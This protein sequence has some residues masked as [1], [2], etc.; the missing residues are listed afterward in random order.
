MQRPSPSPPIP[1]ASAQRMRLLALVVA[2]WLLGACDTSEPRPVERTEP[3]RAP[4][5]VSAPSSDPDK[6][7]KYTLAPKQE[8]TFSLKTP[9]TTITG[10]F[11]IVRGTL[12]I[13]PVNLKNS[14]AHLRIDLGAVRITSGS[15]DENRSYSVS[16]QNWLNLG[17][18]IP[19]ASRDARRW[20]TVLLEEVLESDASSAHDAR[21]DRKRLDESRQASTSTSGTEALLDAG[22]HA[23]ASDAGS[24]PAEIRVVRARVRSSLELNE[25][26]VTQ[27]YSVS[28][29]FHYPAAATPGFPPD[30]VV[31]AS[32]G[33]YKITLDQYQ[34]APR[35]AAGMLVAR[36]LK[37]LGSEVARAA[38]VRF[39]LQFV[40]TA[41]K[42]P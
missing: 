10:V 3:W 16:A 1:A 24:L 2:S 37:L 26:R 20:A 22:A 21:V 33:S 15:D 9:T 34:I 23:A 8:L 13:D 35:N 39:A 6:T 17:A 25:R 4:A 19:E 28:V 7:L 36:D 11:P 31:V 5:A 12:D 41:G 18:S 14:E 32:A 40:P 27:P 42:A 38:Q 30:R 29:E